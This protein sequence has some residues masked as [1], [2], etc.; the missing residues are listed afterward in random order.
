VQGCHTLL[1]HRA[2]RLRLAPWLGLSG[3]LIVLT[4]VASA[5]AAQE[6][7]HPVEVA[8]RAG[9]AIPQGQ[10]EKN[11]FLSRLVIGQAP[12]EL[13][14]SW[15]PHSRW[16]VGALAQYGFVI[17]NDC[18]GDCSGST[19]RIGVQTHHH[20]T[21]DDRVDHWIGI[22]A[23]YEW[24]DLNV[25]DSDLSY[26]GF[27]WVSLMFGEEF[28]LAPRVGIGPVFSLSL[29]EFTHRT[30]IIPGLPDQRG[31]IENRMVHIW[32]SFG[33]RASFGL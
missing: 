31:A 5:R 32:V 8:L 15:R 24:L 12:F 1:L 14:V 7:D 19:R 25:A 17:L 33:V 16:S 13:G 23:G 20:F 3:F 28:P 2:H 10:L 21:P 22:A 29:A 27:E 11:E 4:A 18:E 26:R 6:E 9:W 30:I